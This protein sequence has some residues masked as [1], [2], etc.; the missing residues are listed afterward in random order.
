[1]TTMR[2]S[3]MD[4]EVRRAC[5]HIEK[6]YTDPQLTPAAICAAI[7]TGEP[8][9]NALFDRELGMSIAG[10]IDQVRLHHAKLIAAR[11]PTIPPDSIAPLVG[12]PDGTAL[13]AKFE[14]L[15]GSSFTGYCPEKRT[16]S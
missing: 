13:E 8:F 5:L 2:L 14:A 15:T 12:F 6:S 3:L 16:N 4:P 10:Y 11:D 1:M 9:L 7:V